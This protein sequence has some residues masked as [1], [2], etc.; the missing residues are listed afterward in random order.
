MAGK[1]SDLGPV[2]ENV[3]RT[4]REF[5]ELRR[6][7]Y[8]ELSRKLAQYG[9]EIPT[10]GLR[11]IEAGERRVDVDDLAALA[12]ALNVSPLALLLP[13]RDSRLLPAD[14]EAHHSDEIWRWG[15]GYSPLS[16]VP[17]EGLL[18]ESAPYWAFIEASNPNPSE[19]LGMDIEHLK[20]LSEAFDKF[21]K[22]PGPRGNDK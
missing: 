13:M 18:M 11:R 7:S 15:R 9:R 20:S 4:V 17:G 3:A 21:V 14:E 22:K 10:L 19:D 1:K 2:G 5:R 16:I 12:V 8:A 6:F